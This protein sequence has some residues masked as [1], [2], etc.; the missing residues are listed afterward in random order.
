MNQGF[1]KIT[2]GKEELW[3]AWCRLLMTSLKNEAIETLR[4]EGFSMERMIL[5]EDGYILAQSEGL[6]KKADLSVP[7]NKMHRLLF[8]ECLERCGPIQ[9]EQMEVLY[10]LH[11]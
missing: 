4:Q 9:L 7:L 1:F 2:L 6:G 10:E 5:L 8:K 3:K 11:V